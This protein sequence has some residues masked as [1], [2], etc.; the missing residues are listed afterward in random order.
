MRMDNQKLAT[1]EYKSVFLTRNGKKQQ[2]L[3]VDEGIRR[4][5]VKTYWEFKLN[6][7]KQAKHFKPVKDLKQ[8]TQVK[9]QKHVKHLNTIHY[10][11][12]I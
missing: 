8:L 2:F 4:L 10:N 5:T 11:D 1:V 6:Y 9:H 3:A 12:H 7:L